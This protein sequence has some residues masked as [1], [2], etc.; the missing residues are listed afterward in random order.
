MMHILVTGGLGSVGRGL[1]A[2]LLTRGH[3]VVISSF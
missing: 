3:R 1:V 2:D